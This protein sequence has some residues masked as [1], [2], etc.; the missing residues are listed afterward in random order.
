[1]SYLL[2]HFYA[3]LHIHIGRTESGRAVKITGSKNLTLTNILHTAASRK[4]LDLVG[5]IDCHSPEVI[6]ELEKLIVKEKV[7]EL[8][9]RPI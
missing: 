2:K 8:S 5:I 4:G 6:N 9:V 1:M 3:D 7:T